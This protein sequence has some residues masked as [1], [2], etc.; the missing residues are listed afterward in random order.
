M[1]VTHKK[2]TTEHWRRFAKSIAKKGV[3]NQIMDR[4][5]TQSLWTYVRATE[6]MEIFGSTV[7]A[8]QNSTLVMMY[9]HTLRLVF[10]KLVKNKDDGVL[11]LTFLTKM[12]KVKSD[13]EMDAFVDTEF[14]PK[15]KIDGLEKIPNFDQAKLVLEDMFTQWKTSSVP[16][17]R[18][19]AQWISTIRA[20]HDK[21]VS[22]KS[23]VTLM[24]GLHELIT[25]IHFMIVTSPKA[26]LNHYPCLAS[27][28]STTKHLYKFCQWNKYLFDTIS[29]VSFYNFI[30]DQN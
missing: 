20:V 18:K 11:S 1:S 27:L 10:G 3:F 14:I 22:I 23:N 30:T 6:A 4:A 28:G 19:Q 17:H 12:A 29:E 5:F 25:S 21:L 13:N 16:M 24:K 8:Q 2:P 7:T 26:V 9:L 15:V